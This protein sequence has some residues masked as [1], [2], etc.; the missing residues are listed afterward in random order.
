MKDYYYI[1]G[2]KEN[3]TE[4][5]IK[6]AYRKLSIKFH[7]DKNNGDEFFQ[8]RFVDINEAYEI[9]SDVRKKDFYDKERNNKSYS[10]NKKSEIIHFEVSKKCLYFGDI[11][12]I[13]WETS[14]ADIVELQPF[15]KVN[16]TDSK[17]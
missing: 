8:E 1:L 14:G 9:L 16:P 15:G 12:T 10:H 17:N 6:T 4:K 3:S 7:P 2:V 5:E 13:S 11:L